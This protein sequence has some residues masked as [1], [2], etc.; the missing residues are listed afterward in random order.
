MKWC[1]QTHKCVLLLLGFS[2][3]YDSLQAREEDGK[4]PSQDVLDKMAYV[5]GIISFE[6]VLMLFPA[7]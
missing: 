7:N 2:S 3:A 1:T 5:I 6:P 4:R